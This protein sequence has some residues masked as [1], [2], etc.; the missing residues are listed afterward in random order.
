MSIPE[1]DWRHLRSVSAA[2]LERYSAR[3]LAD[4]ATVIQNARLSNHERYLR[5]HR[6]IQER[7]DDIAKAFNDLRRSTAMQ[8]LASM[9]LLEAV[10]NE[11]LAQFSD[12]TRQSAT[13]L[14]EIFPR[15]KSSKSQ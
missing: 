5:L 3:I 4:C 7:D 13:G 9:I 12:A 10:T 14:A 2:A 8:R 1:R 6:L 15:R 11:E